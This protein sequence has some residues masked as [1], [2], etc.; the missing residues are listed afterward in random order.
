MRGY[1]STARRLTA[2]G[3][4]ATLCGGLRA[5]AATGCRGCRA[6]SCRLCALA[7]RASALWTLGAARPRLL[8][9]IACPLTKHEANRSARE[10]E[11]LAQLVLEVA[12]VAEVDRGRAI[13]KKHER[14]RLA[15]DLG[16]VEETCLL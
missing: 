15:C 16:G 1:V 7:L 3:S 11:R 5:L 9:L 10:P 13:R 12:F 4:G 2:A 14:W 8:E 6:L